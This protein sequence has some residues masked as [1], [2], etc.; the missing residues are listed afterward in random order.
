MLWVERITFFARKQQVEVC[1]F[2]TEEKCNCTEEAWGGDANVVHTVVHLR[3]N[4]SPYPR[5]T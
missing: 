2:H 5:R 3:R 1:I 4:C